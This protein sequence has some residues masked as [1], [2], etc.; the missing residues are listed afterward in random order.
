MSK[1][2]TAKGVVAFYL[3]AALFL[4]FVANLVLAGIFHKPPFLSD[5]WDMLVLFF[6][7]GL[8]VLGI[9]QKEVE[10]EE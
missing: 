1:A 2:K 3:A 8:F 5:I 9:V 6:A 10:L 4:V 7:V